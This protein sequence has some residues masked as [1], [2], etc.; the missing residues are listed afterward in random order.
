MAKPNRKNS[1]KY[2]AE[3]SLSKIKVKVNWDLKAWF[4]K[5]ETDDQ[6]EKDIKRVEKAYA[7]FVKK[8]Q[9]G[10]W[11]KDTQTTLAAIKAY[12]KL[13]ELPGSKPL[14]YLWYRHELDSRDTKAE[15]VSN[16]LEERL[17]KVANSA[18]FFELEL[19]RLPKVKQKTLLESKAARPFAHYLRGLFDHAKYQLTL[20]EEKILNLKANTSRGLWVTATQKI[21]NKQS[22][23]WQGKDL[24]ISGALMQFEELPRKQGRAMWN[25]I[26]PILKQVGEVAENELTALVLDK[27]VS[28]ELRGYKKSYSSTTESFD[29]NDQTLEN[30]VEVVSDKGYKLSHRFYKLK[31]KLAKRPLQY[32]DRNESLGKIPTIEFDTA[33]EIV[34]DIFYGFDRTYGEIFDE[35]LENSQIDVWPKAGKG[36]GAFCCSSVNLPTMVML[37]HNDSL[38]SLRTIAHEMGHAIHAYRSKTQ[39][40]WYEGHSTLTAETASTFFESLVGES[41]IEKAKGK[42]KINLLH[43]SIT[44]RIM[45]MILC[46][47]RF[48][49]EL[50]MHETIRREGAMTGPEMAANLAKHFKR[51]VGGSVAVKDEDG[52]IIHSKPHYRM[53]FYQYSYSFGKI[54]SSI[55]CNRYYE[56]SSYAKEVDKFLCAGESDS[57]ENIFKS[58][59][60]DMSKTDTFLEGLSI[61]EKDIKELEKLTKASRG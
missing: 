59:G 43:D 30:L 23:K 57:V 38:Q 10:S 17:T 29:S 24:P 14:Y 25:K 60:I 58:I 51:S 35:M 4:Y 47:A 52:L 1:F 39:P 53:N 11:K 32:I 5:S 31:S 8:Y 12:L 45:T 33:V 49:A 20:P 2:Q 42:D 48:N 19:A 56:D 13:H 36:G 41:L 16:Q 44:D 6:I 15:K 7:A 46:I 37:N 26:V 27:K 3:Q 9:D 21:L 61:L 34:R 28:D 22:I 18:L 40:S 50:E 55:M 54:G